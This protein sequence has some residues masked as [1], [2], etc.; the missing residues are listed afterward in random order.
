M[1]KRGLTDVAVRNLKPGA[2]RREVPDPG[3]RG[4]YVVVHATGRK[5]YAVRYRF[6]GLPRKLTLQP[7]ITLASA[8]KLAGDAMHAV[9]MGHDP[10]AAKKEAKREAAAAESDTLRAVCE[11]YFRRDG[12]NLR[13][14]AEQERVLARHVY[15]QLGGRQIHQI[16][17][18]EI[19]RLLDRIEDGSGARAADI[20]LAYLRRIMN[21]HAVRDEHFRTPI[22]KGMARTKASE[23]ARSRILA[24]DELRAVWAASAAP[25][26][27]PTLVRFLLLTAARRSEAS[28]LSWAEVA[29][30]GDWTLPAS[31]N[32]TKVDLLRPLS[33]AAL[34][35]LAASPRIDGSEYAFTS[36]G[37][38]PLSG[39][40][41]YKRKFDAAC[42]VTG[43]TLHDLRRTARS[44]MS[45]AGVPSDHAERCLGH[46]IGGVRGVYD[47]H[48]Y[49][50]EKR[51]AYEA[52][53]AQVER[54]VNPADNVVEMRRGADR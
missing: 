29:D 28:H 54:V 24:D 9:A 1:A 41:K 19:I 47:R 25:G 34:A 26:P 8:R 6:H 40:S 39:Y 31:R 2:R 17:R 48:E 13:G 30:N 37:E 12:K 11:E 5:G 35:A 7:G 33:A 20:A 46:V 42:G 10:C 27:F 49:Y 51:A 22:V 38:R 52:L 50:A 14:R 21:W 44:L 45:R 16:A 53:A 18:K 23:R 36:D 43:W 3:Q 4:L 15:P 32:K